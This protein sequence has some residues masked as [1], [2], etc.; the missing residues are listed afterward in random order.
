MTGNGIK[1]ENVAV[2]FNRPQ[3][4]ENIGTAARAAANMGLNELIV[5]RP[6]HL[7]EEIMLSSAT[8][9]GQHL[10]REMTICEELSDSVADFNY[11]VGTTARH[12]AFRGPFHTPRELARELIDVSRENRIAIIFG[13]ERNGLTTTELRLC[14]ATVSIPTASPETSSINLAQAVLIIG[15]ELLMA[16]SSDLPV[17]KPRLAPAGELEEMYEHLKKA[18]LDIEFLKDWNADHRLM[19]LKRLFN[20]AGLTHGDCNLLRGLSRRIE[21]SVKYRPWVAEKRIEERDQD[22]T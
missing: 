18:L 5:V 7:D 3:L 1:L 4:S 6:R 2:V 13:P 8:R 11:V 9:I 10:V 15:Y 16:G 19:S 22:S 21:N 20:R 17:R 14:Q 12:G